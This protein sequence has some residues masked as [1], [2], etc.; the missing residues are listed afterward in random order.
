MDER[1][2]SVFGKE[3]REQVKG[4]GTEGK[5]KEDIREGGR[6]WVSNRALIALA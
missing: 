6:R 1:K 3:G 5:G 2:R 4:T